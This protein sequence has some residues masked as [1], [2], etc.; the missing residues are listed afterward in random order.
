MYGLRFFSI[1]VKDSFQLSLTVLVRY[2]SQVIFRIGSYCL[3]YSHRISDRH[4][5]GY[6]VSSFSRSPEG[7][8][9]SAAR[10]S[11]Q[12][13]IGELGRTQ[14]QTPH[15][16]MVSHADSVCPVPLSVALTK[17]IAIAFFSCRYLDASV[18]GVTVPFGTPEGTMSHSETPSSKPACGY[19]GI[20]AACHLLND[21]LPTLRKVC[22]DIQAILA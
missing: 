6:L 2:R 19:P 4:Y 8:S 5:S 3:P 22:L 9:P 21:R 16:C 17:G 13:R 20:M 14:V 15:P 18:H 12:L 10:L 7:L 11:R 1:P